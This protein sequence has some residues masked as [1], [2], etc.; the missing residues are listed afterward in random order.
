MLLGLLTLAAFV[1]RAQNNELLGEWVVSCPIE[2]IDENTGN[3]CDICP[4]TFDKEKKDFNIKDF[5]MKFVE[6]TV[7]LKTESDLRTTFYD[8]DS[9]MRVLEFKYN[10]KRYVFKVLYTPNKNTLVLK[11]AEGAIVLLIRKT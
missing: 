4:A 10:N 1:S 5:E 8:W 9:F 2:K 11:E 3:M 6:K 7:F